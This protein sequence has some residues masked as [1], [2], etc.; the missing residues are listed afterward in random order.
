MCVPA[1]T[2]IGQLQLILGSSKLRMTDL[3][4]LVSANINIGQ[5]QL[6]PNLERPTFQ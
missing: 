5:L 3:P 4:K 2:D 6:I 1:N